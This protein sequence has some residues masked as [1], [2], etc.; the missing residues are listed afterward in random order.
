MHQKVTRVKA[1]QS[2]IFV[3]KLAVLG[4]LVTAAGLW[5][6]K[7]TGGMRDRGDETRKQAQ[8]KLSRAMCLWCCYCEL[9]ASSFL[10]CK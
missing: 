3:W 9:T 2:N 7:E 10:K 5:P 8:L 4:C 6:A 1:P